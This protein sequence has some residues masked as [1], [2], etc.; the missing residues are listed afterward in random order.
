MFPIHIRPVAPEGLKVESSSAERWYYYYHL[1]VTTALS[2][3]CL[4][5]HW[6]SNVLRPA[7]YVHSM[8][9]VEGRSLFTIIARENDYIFRMT[10]RCLDADTSKYYKY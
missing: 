4:L 8:Y 9:V 5:F 1:Y 6:G 7:Q 2:A 3:V 10:P